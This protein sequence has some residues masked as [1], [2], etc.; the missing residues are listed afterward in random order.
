MRG[1]RGKGKSPFFR[2]LKVIA[3]KK[4]KKKTSQLKP[5]NL[6][7]SAPYKAVSVLFPIQI[8]NTKLVGRPVSAVGLIKV[9]PKLQHKGV[10]VVVVYSLY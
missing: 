10:V 8:S 6:I 5:G 9:A 2:T 7:N 1:S 4:K 3:K